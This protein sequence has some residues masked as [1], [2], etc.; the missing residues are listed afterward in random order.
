[1]TPAGYERRRAWLRTRGFGQVLSLEFSH[2]FE[3]CVSALPDQFANGAGLDDASAGGAAGRLDGVAVHQEATAAE[4]IGAGVRF[5]PND[6]RA[7]IRGIE[8]R[9]ND[10]PA[11]LRDGTDIGDGLHGGIVFAVIE[12]GVARSFKLTVLH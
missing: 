7:M 10:N 1:M 9:A 6:E 3:G 4:G 8:R 12:S 11:A 2:D 5:E